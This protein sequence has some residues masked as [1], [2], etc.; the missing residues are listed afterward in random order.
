MT[1]KDPKTPPPG[2]AQE[3]SRRSPSRGIAR[4]CCPEK[5]KYLSHLAKHKG[6]SIA[7]VLVIGRREAAPCFGRRQMLDRIGSPS[8]MGTLDFDSV[9]RCFAA[10]AAAG[11]VGFIA[12]LVWAWLS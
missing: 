11:F 12:V 1:P 2:P 9:D 4:P 5:L 6:R 7:I 10:M 8:V 3:A